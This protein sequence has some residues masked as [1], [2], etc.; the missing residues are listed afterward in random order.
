MGS[1]FKGSQMK[2]ILLILFFILPYTSIAL[3][4]LIRN[5]KIT[6][7]LSSHNSTYGG[8]M[9]SIDQRPSDFGLDCGS[10]TW[11]SLGCVSDRVSE[12]GAQRM[13][14]IA[15]MAFVLDFAVFIWV[16]DT[17]KH[18]NFCTAIRITSIRPTRS[19]NSSAQSSYYADEMDMP[20]MD[21]DETAFPEP[22]E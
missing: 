12:D 14:Q 16:T 4:E 2:K 3:T 6:R 10:S 20:L 15:E 22:I 9:I 11:I 17:I 18:G 1:L 8:C 5:T 7:M 21:M 13:L 19:N